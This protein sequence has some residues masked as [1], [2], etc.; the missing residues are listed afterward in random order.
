MSSDLFF[1]MSPLSEAELFLLF[2]ISEEKTV[3]PETESEGF[4][5]ASDE[6]FLAVESSW[7]YED[8]VKS[9]LDLVLMVEGSMFGL[10]LCTET[11]ASSLLR[12]L[13]GSFGLVD[14]SWS[15]ED[16]EESLKELMVALL[17][18]SS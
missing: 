12:T 16:P 11:V 17:A 6:F 10:V 7:S 4:L 8:A 13:G 5:V 9:M 1:L 2:L 3:L 18:G 14:D 15:D